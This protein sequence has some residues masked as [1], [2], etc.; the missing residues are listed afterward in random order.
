MSQI[1]WSI[2]F[3]MHRK[4]VWGLVDQQNTRLGRKVSAPQFILIDSYS[5]LTDQKFSPINGGYQF[6]ANFTDV[7]PS[8]FLHQ[9]LRSEGLI[10]LDGVL[11]HYNHFLRTVLERWGRIPVF[12]MEY[13]TDLET[14][15]KFIDR[16]MIIR[17][18]YLELE[19][20][21][22]DVK[23]LQSSGA[24]VG[25]NARE[26]HQGQVFPYHYREDYYEEMAESLAKEFNAQPDLQPR[27]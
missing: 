2:Y 20:S 16:A 13:P 1:P 11:C 26:E 12:L 18:I 8:N 6:Y 10:D 14:R 24:A 4:D 22:P 19:Q 23:F 17:A 9:K 5:E 15:A 27:T 25:P 7:K 21:W 3:S